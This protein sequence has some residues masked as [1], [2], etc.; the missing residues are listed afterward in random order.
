[1]LGTLRRQL[2][3]PA[4]DWL[5]RDYPALAVDLF[6]VLA[7]IVGASWFV[8]LLVEFPSISHPWGLIDRAVTQDIYW[9]TRVGLF[10]AGMP[11][12]VLAGAYL[13]GLAAT[14]A[15]AV[16]WRVRASA[17]VA[18]VVAA[19]AYRWNFVVMY[20]DD[21]VVH[22]LL[23]WML[24]LPAGR[25]LTLAGW[26]RGPEERR[27]WASMRVSGVAVRCLLVNVAW[28]YFMAGV[29][30][31]DSVLWREGL[32]LYAAMKVEVAR[33]ADVWGPEHLPFLKVMDYVVLAVEPVLALPMFLRRGH[34]LRYLGAVSFAGFNLFILATLGITWA[35]VGLTCTLVLFL[36]EEVAD[37]LARALTGNERMAAAEGGAHA[38]PGSGVGAPEDGAVA[39][40]V[41]MRSPWRRADRLAVAFLVL[42]MLATARHVPVFGALNLPAH[43]VLWSVG[44][45]QDY[46]LFNWIDR[47]AYHV[48]T[49]V[50]VTGPGGAPRPVPDG[51]WPDG[52]RAMLL[53]GYAHD[54]RWLVLPDHER[55]RLRL[56]IVR[57]QAS[58]F[59][60]FVEEPGTRVEIVS[61]V[62]PI[63]SGSLFQ[64][65]DRRLRLAEFVCVE[66]G[67][68]TEAEGG[69]PVRR[70]SSRLQARLIQGLNELPIREDEA[71]ARGR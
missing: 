14:V 33:L 66:P 31:L 57:R 8:R 40:A 59:C 6:R 18:L 11:W 1:M 4:A 61:T 23:F 51:A 28:I 50:A 64:A 44:V 46:R 9:F 42:V 37:R 43:V 63:A 12:W 7:G 68:V 29:W 36:G 49:S 55:F 19:S 34:P 32:G 5:G 62:R 53:R 22:L 48:D 56:A 20:L 27:R 54:V 17:A 13:L 60:R 21:A 25:T 52:F 39:D 65:R 38:D 30:K 16:G 26:R 10:Q 35:I 47:V 24:L 15:I 2:V 41:P 67:T 58:W 69:V 71:P 45:G 70:G 3:A